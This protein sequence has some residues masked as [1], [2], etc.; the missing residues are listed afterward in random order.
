MS[1]YASKP[2]ISRG[3]SREVDY[4]L[5]KPSH[6]LIGQ[7]N[8]LLLYWL[9]TRGLTQSRGYPSDQDKLPRITLYLYNSDLAMHSL[10]LATAVFGRY[11]TADGES[12]IHIFP[13]K[14]LY[15]SRRAP[16]PIP[17]HNVNRYLYS[18]RGDGQG[19]S[20]ELIGRLIGGIWSGPVRLGSRG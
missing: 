3:Q 17:L 18:R 16:P 7:M 15:T 19:S 4:L 10:G 13:S 14:I 11:W 5:Y 1:Y 8:V 6:T 12:R 2:T 20:A 9:W